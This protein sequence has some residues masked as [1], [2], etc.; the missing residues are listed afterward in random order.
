MGYDKE[1]ISRFLKEKTPNYGDG[2]IQTLLDML[3]DYYMELNAV[4]NA[5]I[6][7]KFLCINDCLRKL[8]LEENDRVFSEMCSLYCEIECV[9]FS[10]GFRMGVRLMS[11]LQEVY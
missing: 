2:H 4:E 11:E 7:E 3:C 1:M 5:V 10:E 6:R 8:T 9:A